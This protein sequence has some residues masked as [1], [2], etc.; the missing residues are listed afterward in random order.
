MTQRWKGCILN[1]HQLL[2]LRKQWSNKSYAIVISFGR[3]VSVGI[4]DEFNKIIVAL[5]S[6]V[7]T[8]LAILHLY[9]WLEVYNCSASYN[10]IRHRDTICMVIQLKYFTLLLKFEFIWTCISHKACDTYFESSIFFTSH[11]LV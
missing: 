7:Y 4:I 11:H 2:N 10:V 5:L 8:M 6:N 3:L 9:C 1:L